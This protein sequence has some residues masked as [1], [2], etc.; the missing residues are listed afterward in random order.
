MRTSKYHVDINLLC[1]KSKT[2]ETEKNRYHL[3]YVFPNIFFSRIHYSVL[4]LIK[5]ILA[6][7]RC[8]SVQINIT[9]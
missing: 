9:E 3:V 5:S 7:Y 1:F 2:R 6:I 8:F 4:F